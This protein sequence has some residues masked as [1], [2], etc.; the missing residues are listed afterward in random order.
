MKLRT[1]APVAVALI[2]AGTVAGAPIADAHPWNFTS[3][4]DPWSA[5]FSHILGVSPDLNQGDVVG[6][7]QSLMVSV[8]RMPFHSQDNLFG[9]VTKN[10]TKGFQTANGLTSD[11][12]VGGLTW[13][14]AQTRFTTPISCGNAVGGGTYCA[15][16]YIPGSGRPFTAVAAFTGADTWKW[17]AG[18]IDSAGG[19]ATNDP[20]TWVPTNHPTKTWSWH[21]GGGCP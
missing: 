10:A 19:G 6:F 7:W 20:A 9:T 11:G 13:N 4:N 16:Q 18:C 8:N 5:Q 12:R 2:A 1:G 3:V 17:L 15:W 21:Q 14:E